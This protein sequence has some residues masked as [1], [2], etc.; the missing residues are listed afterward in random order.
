MS[1]AQQNTQRRPWA[2]T[3][4]DVLSAR[5]GDS[6][7]LVNLKTDSVH[8]LNQTGARF[9]EL[10]HSENNLDSVQEKLLQEYSVSASA[11]RAEMEQLISSLL[12]RSL[13]IS[14]DSHHR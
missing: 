11:V 1:T 2:T 14:D 10:L 12:D 6:L 9:W 4:S 3:N 5:I 13:I 8:E 7:V